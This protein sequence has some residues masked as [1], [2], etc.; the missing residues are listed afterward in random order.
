M[1]AVNS[2]P[3]RLEK[4]WNIGNTHHKAEFS[5]SMVNLKNTLRKKKSLKAKDGSG[6]TAETIGLLLKLREVI[7]RK[8]SKSAE[9]RSRSR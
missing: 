8:R 9:I 1:G 4:T 6:L 2:A 3:I 5:L 7:K